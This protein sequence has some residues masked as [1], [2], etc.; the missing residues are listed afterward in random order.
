MTAAAAVLTELGIAE[1]VARP[2]FM[3]CNGHHCHVPF[4]SNFHSLGTVSELEMCF[5]S[6]CLDYLTRIGTRAVT[7]RFHQSVE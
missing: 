5:W 3:Y 2:T 6:F 1:I 7:L 4:D